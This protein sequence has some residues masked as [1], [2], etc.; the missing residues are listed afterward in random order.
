MGDKM[1]TYTEFPLNK[2]INILS[3]YTIFDVTYPTDFYFDGEYHNFWEAVCVIDGEIGV[4]AD[5]EVYRIGK[6]QMILHEPMEFHRLWSEGHTMPHLIIL[7][8]GAD[9]MPDV[10]NKLYKLTYECI[11][12][13]NELVRIS[14][15]TFEFSDIN[16][17]SAKAEKEYE[18]QLFT[19]KL[20]LFLA[21]VLN[22][23]IT[24][25]TRYNSNSAKK[26]AMIV[27]IMK[28]NIEKNLTV[29]DIASMCNMSVSNLKKTFS[30]YSRT[31]VMKYFNSLKIK[32]AISM[33]GSG[34]R[35]C[36]IAA[37]LGFEEQNYFSAVF[38]R[39]TGYS[40]NH[41]KKKFLNM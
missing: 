39:L 21:A 4:T 3:V 13:V 34:S 31:G 36:E 1:R 7:S 23:E 35:I 40:P 5:N 30:Q 29:S 19:N 2:I 32:K 20:E 41:Y 10:K 6:G 15:E 27:D 18:I 37:E 38:K 12:M 33:L 22:N 17:A 14:K 11:D 16:V 26:Y 28:E 9:K 24:S 8:F 25:I